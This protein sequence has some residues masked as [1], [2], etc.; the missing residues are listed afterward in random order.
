[1]TPKPRP[2]T[3]SRVRL[4]T[5]IVRRQP[6]P[7]RPTR[8]LT[9]RHTKS[10]ARSRRVRAQLAKKVN[11]KSENGD[12]S[13]LTELSDSD[14]DANESTPIVKRLR[15][16]GVGG[17]KSFMKE[18]S[19]DI[20]DF[21]DDA[22]EADAEATE[23]EE[24]PPHP[25]GRKLR[26]ISISQASLSKHGSDIDMA[27]VSGQ[28]SPKSLPTRGAKKKAIQRMQGGESGTE[29]EDMEMDED[30]DIGVEEG[31]PMPQPATPP[32]KGRASRLSTPKL[33]EDSAMVGSPT[34]SVAT[35]TE[36]ATPRPVHTTRSG[37]AFGAIQNRRRQLLQE[38]RNDP[39]MD[40]EDESD[41]EDG[42]PEPD[43]DLSE[44]TVASLIRLLRDELVQMCEAR[45][46]E[47]GGT[48]PQLAKALLEWVSNFPLCSKMED[49]LTLFSAMSKRAL[50]HRQ[51]QP[52][53]LLLPVLRCLDASLNLNLN[54]EL[55]PSSSP[56]S[57][58]PLSAP[59]FTHPVNLRQFFFA[60]MFMP[61]IPKRH[62]CPK[63][64]KVTWK[65]KRR[66][67]KRS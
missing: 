10:E 15:P 33:D 66:G 1:M 18:P 5:P 52:L 31:M 21:E 56:I 65:R 45:G 16:R 41:E 17:R 57:M 49:L 60:H 12:E 22:E 2:R 26:S 58:Y 36:A 25:K 14:D 3:R 53:G 64:R 19:T 59:P 61:T 11:G 37:K 34:P 28:R 62:L 51:P 47:V 63:V 13:E 55:N 35:E 40:E 20:T 46:I 43:I 50:I 67:Q 8:T 44:A 23:V 9:K 29:D 6:R 54:L 4:E 30:K 24:E 39:D 32:R 27:P 38:A 7:S 48:K 42:E